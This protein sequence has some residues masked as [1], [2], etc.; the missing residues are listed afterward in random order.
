MGFYS[1]HRVEKNI[2]FL[3]DSYM[4]PV[5]VICVG[6]AKLDIFLTIDEN[7]T[8]VKLDNNTRELRFGHG[9]K[10]EVKKMNLSVG[11]NASNVAVGVSR[12]G[13]KSSLVAEI[14]EDEFSQ[15]IINSLTQ[16]NVD[17]ELVKQIA[18]EDSSITVGINFK[19]DRTLFTEHVQREHEFDFGEKTAKVIYLTSLGPIWEKAY[20]KTLDFTEKNNIKLIFNPGTFQ[21]EKRNSIIWH[22]IS[23]SDVLFVNKEEAEELLYG[24]EINLSI[25]SQNYVKKLLYG[26]K[27]LGAKIV[28]I[29]DGNAGSFAM[30]GTHN[31]YQLGIIPCEVVEK[32]GAGDAYTSGFISA[33]LNGENIEEAMR[34]GAFNSSAV[35]GEIGAE[36]GL[37]TKEEILKKLKLNRDFK[38]K[39]I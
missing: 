19:G 2:Q 33:I 7:N 12:L 28:A 23:K 11:G 24:K 3:Y 38:A 34:W 21:I 30:D 4:L 29:T 26:L 15:K 18:N 5:D 39:E 1:S 8:H 22:I 9:E 20:E 31:A 35:I 13:L 14:G 27:S 36:K 32:T 37:L 16:E 17:L 10:I 25:N 6:D